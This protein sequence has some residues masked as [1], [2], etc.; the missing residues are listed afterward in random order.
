MYNMKSNEDLSPTV[1][2]TRMTQQ[3]I[4]LLDDVIYAYKE[5]YH[6]IAIDLVIMVD[7]LVQVGYCE[8]LMNII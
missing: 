6:Y 2:H 7:I 1:I 3:W 4:N 5:K 8:W